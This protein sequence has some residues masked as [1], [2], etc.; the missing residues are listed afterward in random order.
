MRIQLI[1]EAILAAYAPENPDAYELPG[2][3]TVGQL[4]RHLEVPEDLVMF[5]IVDGQ[6]ATLET[7]LHENATVSLCPYICGG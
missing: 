7:V 2:E 4:I 1:L 5:A 3:M 6:M